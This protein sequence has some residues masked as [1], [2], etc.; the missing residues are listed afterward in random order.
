MEKKFE[1]KGIVFEGYK[2]LRGR[3]CSFA[4]ISKRIANIGVTPAW[5]NY[6]E[7]YKIAKDNDCEFDLYKIKHNKEI[8]TIIPAN[9]FL[10][11]YV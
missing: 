2:N 5:W 8:I 11:K 1:Y 4:N 7:F 10:F 6:D 3:A 9:N